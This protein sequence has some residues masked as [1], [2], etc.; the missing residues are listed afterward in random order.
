MKNKNQIIDHCEKFSTIQAR[1]FD[2]FLLDF[3]AQ[4]EGFDRVIIDL[5]NKYKHVLRKMP[6]EFIGLIAAQLIGGKVF[7]KN[8]LLSK[9]L[10]HPILKQLPEDQLQLLLH[11]QQNPW[12]YSF[13]KILDRP[14]EDFFQMLDMF[15]GEKFLVYSRGIESFYSQSEDA[16]YFNLL[17]FNGQCWQTNGNIAY[18]KS[19]TADDIFYFA[20]SL[21]P[22]ID[23]DDDL[24]EYVYLNPYPFMLLYSGAEYPKTIA[25][26]FVQ[27]N[28]MSSIEVENL[29]PDDFR[30]EFKVEW[31]K[32]VYR[33]THQELS[34]FPHLAEAFWDEKEGLF[35][36]QALTEEGYE[37]QSV[38]LNQY[39]LD[40]LP[41]P[42]LKVN[43]SMFVAIRD[44][45]KKDGDFHNYARLFSD[46]KKE[47][48]PQLD[49]LNHFMGLLLPYFNAGTKPDLQ[50]L[51]AQANLPLQEAEDLYQHLLQQF[52][53]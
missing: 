33:F 10:S 51:A 22:S 47:S 49:K 31:N 52:R 8:G 44:I 5:E 3:I 21:E 11:Y 25:R 18:F 41:Y 43:L 50:K 23:D 24:I 48:D 53:K 27:H 26:G 28:C 12:K 17:S 7:Q 19:F 40:F 4:R 30:K 39:G 35:F 20:I 34:A 45:L 6:K 42:D 14:A 16:L 13:S 36:C 2:H 9:Y 38:I 15:T 32:G 37:A 1:V 29:N 46:T